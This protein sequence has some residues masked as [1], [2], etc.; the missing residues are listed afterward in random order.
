MIPGPLDL[1][2]G[3]LDLIPGPL[4]LTPGPLDLIPGPLD[5]TPGPVF[6]VGSDL[7]VMP[8]VPRGLVALE[9]YAERLVV[10]GR[11]KR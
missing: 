8:D 5:L 4:D 2:P 6:F 3:P 10:N 9:T 11:P 1:T 7:L